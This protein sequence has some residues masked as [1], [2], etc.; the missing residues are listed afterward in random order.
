MDLTSDTVT[1][2]KLES[3]YTAHDASGTQITG[4]GSGGGGGGWTL[5]ASTEAYISYADQTEHLVAELNITPSLLWDPD[6]LIVGVVHRTA[7]S[8]DNPLWSM[9]I[10]PNVY[11][12]NGGTAVS[13]ITKVGIGY[14]SGSYKI[15]E[16]VSTPGV[17]LKTINSSGV[18]A[19]YAK[20]NSSL[21][22]YLDGTYVLE[23][24]S[25]E[26]PNNIIPFDI[27]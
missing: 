19:F 13:I 15:V 17:Y 24:W 9:A 27:S 6:V 16:N 20:Y 7:F 14:K 10:I 8:S 11:A 5:L 26:Y 21:G 1:A 25:L 3:G 4:T 23:V 12:V 18:A 22:N 2:A